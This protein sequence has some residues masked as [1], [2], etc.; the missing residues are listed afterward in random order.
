MGQCR[1][2][3]L[4]YLLI[5]IDVVGDAL[6]LVSIDSSRPNSPST[7]NLS[8]TMTSKKGS[9]SKKKKSSKPDFLP[10]SPTSRLV[11]H[12]PF[13]PFLPCCPFYTLILLVDDATSSSS[14]LLPLSFIPPSFLFSFFSIF[15]DP[16]L[17]ID[18]QSWRIDLRAPH[19]RRVLLRNAFLMHRLAQR[20]RGAIDPSASNPSDFLS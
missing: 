1:S 3:K 2:S 15:I 10:S 14:S 8:M 13:D 6:I 18:P 7:T 11:R 16:H 20:T 4:F 19:R 12:L 5:I 17:E 9:R